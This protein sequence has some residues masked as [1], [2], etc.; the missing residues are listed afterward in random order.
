[1]GEGVVLHAVSTAVDL[2]GKAGM[3]GDLLPDAEEGGARA[4]LLETIEDGRRDLRV[5]AVTSAPVQ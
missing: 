2:R 1:M 5:R 3:G 4:A